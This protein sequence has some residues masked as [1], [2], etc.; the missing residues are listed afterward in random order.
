MQKTLLNQVYVYLIPRPPK[1]VTF[2]VRSELDRGRHE[3]EIK[4]SIINTC[5]LFR[6]R[7]YGVRS[8]ATQS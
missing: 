7:R 6:T 5:P 4:F 1:P 8:P 2:A 3:T